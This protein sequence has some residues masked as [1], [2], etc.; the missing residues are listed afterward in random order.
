MGLRF[1]DILTN[2]SAI[3]DFVGEQ[4]VTARHML[5][6]VAV[7]QDEKTMDD[8]GKPVSPMLR[9]LRGPGGAD[10]RVRELAQRW[11]ALLGSDLAAELSGEQL[12]SL[13]AE[14]HEMTAASES[15]P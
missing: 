12:A 6:A 13:L 8:F 5:D 4:N 1:T 2:A 9:R 15:P 14:L 7:L 3:A 10:P 11:F